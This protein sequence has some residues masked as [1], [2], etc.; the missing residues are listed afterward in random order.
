MKRRLL[1]IGLAFIFSSATMSNAYDTDNVHPKINENALIQSTVDSYLKSQL[2]FADGIKEVF[3]KKRIAEWIKDGARLEDETVCRSRNHFHDPLKSWGSAGLNNAAVNSY[4]LL[5]NLEKFSVDSSLMWAQKESL[6]PFYDNLW[7]WPKARN[8]YF[9]ALT[10]SVKDERE[11]N[12]AYT[13]RALGQVAHL[14]ADS[15]VPAHVRNDIHVFPITTAF[16]IT[17]GKRQTYE[18]WAMKNWWWLNYSGIKVDTSIFNQAVPDSPAPVPISALWDQNKYVG[19]NASV[20]WSTNPVIS[21]YGLAEYTNANFFSE[22]TIFEAYP[23]PNKENTTAKL[24][25]QYAKDGKKDKVWYIQGYT[26][27]RLAAYSYFNKWLLPDRW[28]YN[29]DDYVYSDYASQLIPRAVGYSAGLLDYFFRGDIDLIPDYETGSGY[30][31]VNNTDEDM[32]GIFELWYDNTKDERV[33]LPNGPGFLKIGKKSVGNNRSANISF[34]PP[35]DAKKTGSYMLVFRGQLGNEKD[36]IVGR[37]LSGRSGIF[38]VNY[39]GPETRLKQLFL[40]LNTLNGRYSTVPVKYEAPLMGYSSDCGTWTVISDPASTRHWLTAPMAREEDYQ[41]HLLWY[42]V[43]GAPDDGGCHGTSYLWRPTKFAYEIREGESVDYVLTA[44]PEWWGRGDGGYALSALGRKN[45]T[46]DAGGNMISNSDSVWSDN[47]GRYVYRHI[48]G[49]DQGFV[50][51]A[52]VG[53]SGRIVP[54]T[55][56]R[57]TT[58]VDSG[59]SD[60]SHIVAALG[61]GKV[62]NIQTNITSPYSNVLQEEVELTRFGFQGHIR[63]RGLESPPDTNKFC[64]VAGTARFSATPSK[65]GGRA[66]VTLQ[67]GGREVDSLVEDIDISRWDS[68]LPIQ[69]LEFT[70]GPDSS[71][72]PSNVSVVFPEMGGHETRGSITVHDYDNFNGDDTYVL[73]YSKEVTEIDYRQTAGISYAMRLLNVVYVWGH[74]EMLN[75]SY[76]DDMGTDSYQIIDREHHQARNQ[77]FLVYKIG[78][79]FNKVMLQE[80]NQSTFVLRDSQGELCDPGPCGWVIGEG[81]GTTDEYYPHIFTGFST[82]LNKEIMVYTYIIKKRTGT[83]YLFDRRVVGII[84]IADE[85]LPIGYRQE[86]T[87]DN[88]NYSIEDFD[89]TRVSAVGIH[90]LR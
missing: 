53:D 23:H 65:I 83:E 68:Y 84:N 57:S 60:G 3:K 74:G 59:A 77:L 58:R 62:I 14:I 54:M 8:Y 2:G 4:C 89:F 36:A 7:A 71:F 25:E 9:K 24:V 66:A 55:A 49:K 63:C 30:V 29:L 44:Q 52:V 13:F 90:K 88:E 6:N 51:V 86:F 27:Q 15:S 41:N 1:L 12:F 72:A 56:G 70:G 16:G 85:R 28:Q 50:D 82:Q 37:S 11:K 80:E 79:Q 46:L 45:Y 61:S 21:E 78:D 26:S 42:G 38:L 43:M 47:Y 39:S 76:F 35:T 81:G 32:S 40:E 67:V 73:L 31:I 64:D 5:L 17:L 19:N 22:D 48:A 69:G 33:K 18:S 87:I 20:T 10:G 34:L 75:W